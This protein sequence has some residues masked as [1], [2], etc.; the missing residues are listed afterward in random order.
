M[1]KA[2]PQ[3]GSDLNRLLKN[4]GVEMPEKTFVGDRSLVLEASM[5]QDARPEKIMGFL[6]LTRECMN[7]R[8]RHKRES[9]SGPGAVCRCAESNRPGPEG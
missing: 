6:M 2:M 3:R 5:A 4:W 8:V 1:M 9:E 7:P